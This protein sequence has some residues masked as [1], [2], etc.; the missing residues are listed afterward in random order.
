MELSEKESKEKPRNLWKKT[1]SKQYQVKKHYF[2]IY[3]YDI[4]E[5]L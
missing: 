2:T 5:F 3:N 4:I 1:D